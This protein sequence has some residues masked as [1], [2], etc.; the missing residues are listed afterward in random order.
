MS[1][2]SLTV[3]SSDSHDVKITTEE[4]FEISRGLEPHHAVFYQVWAMG[5]PIFDET[6]PT[7]CVKFDEQGNFVWFMFNPIFWK[8][9]DFKNKLFVIAHEAL[10]IVLN[11]GIRGKDAGINQT[12][13]NMAMDI[14]VNHTLTRS[15]GFD[16]N[17]IDNAENYC[18][19]DTVFKDKKP[20]PKDNEMFEYYY[21]LFEKVYGDFGMGDGSGEGVPVTVDDHEGLQKASKETIGKIIDQLN[22]SLSEEEKESLK[23]MVQKHF[24]KPHPKKD[25]EAGSSSGGQWVFAKNTHVKKKKK[26]ETIIKK[27]SRKHL[28]ES[29]KDVEQWAKIH[30]RMVL[31]PR[32][33]ILPSDMEI[34]AFDDD[35]NKIDVWFFLDTSGSC[36]DL[37]DRFFA[38]AESLPDHRFNVRLFCFDTTV[39]ETNL[40]S[41]KIYG[42]GGTS[43]QI[44]EAHIKNVVAK[45]NIKYPES[46]WVI[47]DGYGD[48]I[49]PSNPDRW[50]WFITEGGSKSYIDAKCNFYDL[51]EFE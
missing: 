4:W 48:R 10:H 11:H 50:H 37:K 6:I 32:T 41:R 35:K 43:F 21:N 31:L 9:L 25:S 20:M 16:R 1:T 27:W 51:R 34:Q 26:W 29:D 33:M 24:Q 23:N 15:F 22:E 7:A 19:V 28:Y 40:Q 42:G 3:A 2:P 39:Q 30:R 46:I 49:M 5:R 14:V 12:A 13:C 36:W 17:E 8:S 47:T 18:W 38:A 45:E 44:I